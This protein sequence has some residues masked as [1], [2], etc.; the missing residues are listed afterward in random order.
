[1]VANHGCA[2]S[3]R[4]KRDD[5]GRITGG[6]VA[7][8]DIDAQRRAQDELQRLNETLEQRVLETA[9]ERERAWR[10]SQELLTVVEADGSF[11]EI[12]AAWHALLGWEPQDLLGQPLPISPIPTTWLRPSSSS[13]PYSRHP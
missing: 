10:V 9:A 12:N 8:L 5:E 13:P 4:R 2:S 7:S 1:M 3:P 6:V 11:A